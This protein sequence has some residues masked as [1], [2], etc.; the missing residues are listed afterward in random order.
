VAALRDSQNPTLAKAFIA[1]LLG[2]GQSTLAR[3][4]FT[5]P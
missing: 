2:D 3:Y 5:G 1:Y 4:G